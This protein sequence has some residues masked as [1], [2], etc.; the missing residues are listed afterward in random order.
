[1]G[2]RT[3]GDFIPNTLKEIL[4]ILFLTLLLNTPIKTNAQNQIPPSKTSAQSYKNQ[5]VSYKI[6]DAKS[7]TYG[8]NIFINDSLFIHQPVIPCIAGNKG[9]KSK[10]EARKVATLVVQKI[11]NHVIPPSISVTEM[12][13]LGISL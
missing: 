13:E 12:K 6:I 1:M 10:A 2:C 7:H 8:Y 11:R 3:I 4:T 5:T 9:F